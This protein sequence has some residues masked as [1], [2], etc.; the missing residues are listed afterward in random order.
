M[1]SRAVSACPLFRYGDANSVQRALVVSIHDVAPSTRANTEKILA[2]L[3][4]H[5]VNTCSLLVVPDYHHEGP[6]LADPGFRS[7]LEQMNASGHEIVLH[8]FFHERTRKTDESAREKIVTRF[9]TA[10]E[11]EF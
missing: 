3:A 9:Y 5:Q 11:G 8:G 4:R 2:D 10:D 6:S 1:R 7:W